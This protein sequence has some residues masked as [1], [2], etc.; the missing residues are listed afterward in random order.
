MKYKIEVE[1]VYSQIYIIE[2]ENKEEAEQKLSDG[3]YFDSKD[4]EYF[5]EQ[6]NTIEEVIEDKV[7]PKCKGLL[8]KS[9]LKDYAYDCNHCNEDFYKFEAN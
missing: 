6:I 5:E 3:D 4:I 8:T 7:C 1:G 2:A 9:A